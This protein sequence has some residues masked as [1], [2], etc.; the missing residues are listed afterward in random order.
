[1]PKLP[2][3]VG[4]LQQLVIGAEKAI[5]MLSFTVFYRTTISLLASQ[6]PRIAL[7]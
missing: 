5:S 4:S 1:M 2:H 3:Q 6:N 7:W